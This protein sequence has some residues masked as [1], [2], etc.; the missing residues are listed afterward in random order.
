MILSKT[1]R[2]VFVK[3][4]KVAG[5]SVEM[6]ISAVCGPDDIITPITPIDELDR[7]NMGCRPAQNYSSDPGRER[8]Y[9]ISIRTADLEDLSKIILPTGVFYNHMP[10]SE[11]VCRYG[12]IP[13][14]YIICCIER[15]PYRKIISWANMAI[16]FATYHIGRKM[17]SDIQTLTEFIDRACARRDILTVKNIDRYRSHGD[18]LGLNKVMRYEDIDRDFSDLM[19]S[20]GVMRAPTV[21]HAKRGLL[22][23]SLDIEEIFKPWHIRMINELFYE[24][25]DAFNY[26]MIYR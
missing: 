22:S 11:I 20:V 6:A 19:K 2:L 5:T 7:M 13:S 18:G 25:F 17:Q 8:D 1:L 15:C 24:E 9:L 26:D 23:N 3:G 4:I 10:L 16:S 14:D 21:P 12:D